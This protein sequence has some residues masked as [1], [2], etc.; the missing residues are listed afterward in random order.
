MLEVDRDFSQGALQSTGMNT[1]LA[2]EGDGFFVVNNNGQNYYS[3]AG[4]FHSIKMDS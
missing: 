4:I 1:D 2:I 3:R